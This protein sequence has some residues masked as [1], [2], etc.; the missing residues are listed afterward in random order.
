MRTKSKVELRTNNT[1]K[2]TT[3]MHQTARKAM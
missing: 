1:K 2:R 3:G